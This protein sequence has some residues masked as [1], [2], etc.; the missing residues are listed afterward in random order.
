YNFYLYNSY[1]SLL[2][3]H[4]WVA[5]EC[6]F[7]HTTPP[8]EIMHDSSGA[9]LLAVGLDGAAAPPQAAK[10]RVKPGRQRRRIRV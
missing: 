5:S 2:S 1:L 10:A 3:S 7:D 9:A 6:G 8:V 4:L